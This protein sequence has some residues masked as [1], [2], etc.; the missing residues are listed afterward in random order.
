MKKFLTFGILLAILVTFSA[1]HSTEHAYKSAYDKVKQ[2]QK[3]TM[4]ISGAVKPTV[5]VEQPKEVKAQDVPREQVTLIVGKKLDFYNVIVNSFKLR[6][7]AEDL[8]ERLV[9][10]GY[11]DA[12]VIF[13]KVA[14]Y[15]RVV[16]STHHDFDSA[17][18]SRNDFMAKFSNRKD[19]QNTWIA[20]CWR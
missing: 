19:F 8:Q 6:V 13:D 2:I 3:D 18:K 15:Y 16:L 4:A 11:K 12:S 20:F 9:K 7:T 5:V 17:V 1:C 14:S 10:D